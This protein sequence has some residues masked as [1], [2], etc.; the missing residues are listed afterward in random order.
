ME[1]VYVRVFEG[2]PTAV[3][4]LKKSVDPKKC[5]EK[6]RF[7]A[8]LPTCPLPVGVS[9]ATFCI[10]TMFVT[11]SKLSYRPT[12]LLCSCFPLPLSRLQYE[13]S[14]VLARDLSQ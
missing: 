9:H 11:V 12:L 1:R 5:P 14:P 6:I 7:V 2:S 10:L 3:K 8:T 13:V 4:A